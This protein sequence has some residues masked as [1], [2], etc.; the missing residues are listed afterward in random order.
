VCESLR[1][2]S[3]FFYQVFL[4][5]CSPPP[6]HVQSPQVIEKHLIVSL[7]DG[8]HHVRLLHTVIIV[9]GPRVC[10]R[11]FLGIYFNQLL[12]QLLFQFLYPNGH[13]RYKPT[14]SVFVQARDRL[15]TKT[16][17]IIVNIIIKV[18]SKFQSR[19]CEPWLPNFCF[20]FFSDGQIERICPESVTD[21]PVRPDK[22]WKQISS[23]ARMPDTGGKGKE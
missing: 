9:T 15:G 13:F 11:V 23:R 3:S 14:F 7:S 20:I 12:W 5:G 18:H 6:V 19:K 16:E 10:K 1:S 17:I 21:N 8:P 4:G 2:S 22:S